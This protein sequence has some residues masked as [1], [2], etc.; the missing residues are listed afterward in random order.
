M[1]D[2]QTKLT[3]TIDKKV[4]ENAKRYAARRKR[5]ISRMVEEYLRNISSGTAEVDEA[6][7]LHNSLTEEI[8][9]MF[10]EDFSGQEYD[11]LLEEALREKKL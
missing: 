1:G 5:S 9:G 11:E 10:A 8:T 2:L 7:L 4:V 6:S 3:L